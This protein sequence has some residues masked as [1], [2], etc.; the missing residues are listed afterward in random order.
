MGAL[1]PRFDGPPAVSSDIH[2]GAVFGALLRRG[3][4]GRT[5]S[6]S[7]LPAALP[8]PNTCQAFCAAR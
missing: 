8:G 4:A 2:V 1:V 6:P 5:T 7:S 3:L